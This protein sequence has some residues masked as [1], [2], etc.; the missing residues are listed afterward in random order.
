MPAAKARDT[1]TIDECISALPLYNFYS[2]SNHIPELP[3]KQKI[4]NPRAFSYC[5]KVGLLV[6]CIQAL[7]DSLRQVKRALDHDN[8][9]DCIANAFS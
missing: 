7:K 3:L 2:S 9:N 1:H 6:L 4:V 8:G 5:D